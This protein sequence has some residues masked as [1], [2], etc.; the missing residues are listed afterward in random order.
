MTVAYVIVHTLSSVVIC[1]GHE[2]N[3]HL[4]KPP[5]N[6]GISSLWFLLLSCRRG[7][8][9]LHDNCHTKF[10]GELWDWCKCFPQN[11]CVTFSGFFFSSFFFFA[12]CHQYCRW[13]HLDACAPNMVWWIRA[14]RS[15]NLDLLDSSYSLTSIPE[16]YWE[17]FFQNKCICMA[18]FVLT[19]CIL[20]F[21]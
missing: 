10:K 6:G 20:W 8:A 14:Q 7:P 9:M 12:G 16:Y 2:R 5:W 19:F 15:F 1:R 3:N 18:V 13:I 17:H 11:L 4:L 21:R